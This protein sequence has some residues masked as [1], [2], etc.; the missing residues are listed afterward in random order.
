MTVAQISTHF[1]FCAVVIV[2]LGAGIDIK[3]HRIPNL[4]VFPGISGA[5]FFHALTQGLGGFIFSLTGL[6]GGIGLLLIPFLFRWVGAGDAKFLGFIGAAWGWPSVFEI[7]ILA[8]LSGGVLALGI[9]IANP[10]VLK[11]LLRNVRYFFVSFK[12]FAV[13]SIGAGNSGEAV[14]PNGESSQDDTNAKSQF[15]IPYGVAI[16]TGTVIWIALQLSGHPL[17]FMTL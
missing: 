1:T 15:R 10:Q 12:N 14:V 2:L 8:T 16:A 6:F 13:L 3:R 11:R 17:T 4:L 7:F 9:M 5:V